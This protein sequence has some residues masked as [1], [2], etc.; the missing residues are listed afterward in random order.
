MSKAKQNAAL[1][2]KT[3][4][5]IAAYVAVYRDLEQDIGYTRKGERVK[6][7]ALKMLLD[8][9]WE[10]ENVWLDAADEGEQIAFKTAAG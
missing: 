10:L 4:E 7:K 2:K 5:L 1:Q 8:R 3:K 9:L 6:K